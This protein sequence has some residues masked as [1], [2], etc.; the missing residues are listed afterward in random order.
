MPATIFEQKLE[1]F[2]HMFYNNTMANIFIYN[3]ESGKGKLGKY[4]EYILGELEKKYG[5][6]EWIATNHMGHAFELAKEYGTVC[7]YLFVSGGDG[8]LNEVVNGISQN[9]KK[10]IIGYIPS[11]TVNDV[12]RSLG[13]SKNVKKAVKTLVSGEVFEHDTFKVNGKYGIYVCCAGLF[14]KTSYEA[15]RYE[16]KIFGRLA[17]L[18]SGIRE[19]FK[20]KPLPIELEVGDEKFKENCALLLILNSRSV[21]GFKINKKAELDDGVVELILYKTAKNHIRLVDILRI[22]N[23]FL[24]GIKHIKKTNKVIYKALPSFTLHTSDETPINLDGEKCTSGTFSF[25][26]LNKGIKILVP[27]K[28]R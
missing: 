9:E 5:E 15:K 12:A 1:Y 25:E 10:P 2:S 13:I 16:K 19:I 27:N 24:F 18:T 14:S 4:K 21:A 23:T 3:P 6:T 26:C 17:Y 7:D 11:G 28:K 22:V 20:T 8:T